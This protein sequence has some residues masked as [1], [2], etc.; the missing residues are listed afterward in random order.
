MDTI[1]ISPGVF[2][3]TSENMIADQKAWD[4]EDPAKNT[5]F[6]THPFWITTDS[7]SSPDGVDQNGLSALLER[8][9]IEEPEYD[10][11]NE[12]WTWTVKGGTIQQSGPC[13]FIF[14][15]RMDS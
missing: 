2:V 7:G 13:E 4:S 12:T 14:S 1:E 3:S 10:W 15:R 6:S 11:Q 5:D 8:L 9:E